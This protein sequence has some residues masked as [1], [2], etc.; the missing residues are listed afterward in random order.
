MTTR[1]RALV[2][3]GGPA[4]TSA[5]IGLSRCGYEVTL[6]EQR[7]DWT[8]RVCGS[9][10]NS[11]AVSHL[12]WLGALD[13]IKKNSIPVETTMISTPFTKERKVSMNGAR[14]APLALPRQNLEETLLR[15]ASKE[16]AHISMG[17]RIVD[18]KHD[19]LTGE[20]VV[21]SQQIEAGH[22]T[23]RSHRT[24]L[25]VLADGRFSI[26]KRSKAKKTGWYGWNGQFRNVDQR[27]GEQSLNFFPGGYVGVLTFSN[28]ESNVCGLIKKTSGKHSSWEDVFNQSLKAHPYLRGRLQSAERVSDWKGVGPLP[29]SSTIQWSP[30]P[31]AVGDAAAVGDPFMGEGIGRALGAGPMLNSILKGAVRVGTALES[32]QALWTRHYRRR[33]RTA[34]A[35]RF[36]IGHKNLFRPTFRLLQHGSLLEAAVPFFHSGFA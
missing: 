10:L 3:G 26:L 9:F 35:A 13:E 29:F 1:G 21:D 14:Q 19:V 8:G 18:F 30:G 27:P 36:V 4:G 22:S 7:R 31:F 24:D 6:L 2:I 33:L 11:E 5:A 32:Y 12:D 34:S 28:G 25:V 16:G 15:L 17:E 20:W 23:P